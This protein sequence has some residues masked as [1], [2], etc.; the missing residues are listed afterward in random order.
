MSKKDLAE[1]IGL[2][3]QEGWRL[4]ELSCGSRLSKYKI[5][6]LLKFGVINQIDSE[7]LRLFFLAK[8]ADPF[9]ILHIREIIF[10]RKFDKKM[11]K[12]K[13][14]APEFIPGCVTWNKGA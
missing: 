14:S 1:K 7:K 12:I 11:E 4:E 6:K 3:R 8:E 13:F 5:S 2:L 10:L 9:Y